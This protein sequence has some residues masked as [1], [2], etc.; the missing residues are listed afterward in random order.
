MGSW[1]F[2]CHWHRSRCRH[3]HTTVAVA[4]AQFILIVVV[5]KNSI[6]IHLMGSVSVCVSHVFYSN[7][8]FRLVHLSPMII[9]RER[10]NW[11]RFL[12]SSFVNKKRDQ[13]FVQGFCDLIY[14][15]LDPF[16]PLA[17]THRR[18]HTFIKQFQLIRLLVRHPSEQKIAIHR[19]F[20]SSFLSLGLSRS[21]QS[22]TCAP[23]AQYPL[24]H[25]CSYSSRFPLENP[26]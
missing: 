26:K 5:T 21:I 8:L 12:F 2:E 15:W 16:Q 17:D 1:Q 24:S 25:T 3:R 14:G 18:T 4:T 9:A 11:S 19:H 10:L 22:L 13:A 6:F 23:Q 20:L 7:F